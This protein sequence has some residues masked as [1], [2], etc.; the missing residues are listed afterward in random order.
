MNFL[1]VVNKLI[2]SW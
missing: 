2:N 1:E